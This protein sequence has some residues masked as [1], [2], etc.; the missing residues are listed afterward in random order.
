MKNINLLILA[1]F[2][3]FVFQS[4]VGPEGPQGLP[5]PE[6]EPGINILSEVFELEIDFNEGNNFEEIRDFNP[7][8]ID[9]DMVIAFIQWDVNGTSPIWRALP[10]TVFFEEGV[11]MYNYDFTNNDFR[12]FLDGPLDYSLLGPEWTDNQL[13]RVVVVPG[14][15]LSANA[16]IDLTDY[17][18]VTKLMG[19]SDSDFKRIE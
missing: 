17:N 7:A 12:L 10:Q 13:F 15:L 18:T 3:M 4:C 16:R 19:L 8:I 1:L 2:G 6:G 9:G 14:E 11:L 5:G